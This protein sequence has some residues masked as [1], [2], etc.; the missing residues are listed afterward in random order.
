MNVINPTK[1]NFT[2]PL[3][4]KEIRDELETS[5]DDYYIALSLSKNEDLELYLK[6]QPKFYFVINYFDV[7][8]KAWQANMDT[9]CF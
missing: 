3:I 5:R 1:E 4:I 9:T 6:R 8:L 2:Q 7:D